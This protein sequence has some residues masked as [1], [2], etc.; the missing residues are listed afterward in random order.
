MVAYI[1]KMNPE[2][3]TCQ[4]LDTFFRYFRYR[5]WQYDNPLHLG[6]IKADPDIV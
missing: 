1:C 5:K 4:L 2:L 6:E 3:E